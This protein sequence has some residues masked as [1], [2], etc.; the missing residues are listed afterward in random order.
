[1][2]LAAEPAPRPASGRDFALGLTFVLMAFAG[3]VR[4]FAPH[5]IDDAWVTLRYSRM[6]AE[7]QGLVFNPGEHVEGY[8]NFLL[9]ALLTPVIRNG[10]ADAALP[11]A[12]GVGL[13]ASLLAI[14]GAG[15]VAR[16]AAAGERWADVAG[17][18]AAALV[19]CSTGFAYYA[20]SGLETS[21][22]A[23]LL[24]W[25]ALGI[26]SA[27]DGGV[28]LG[29]LVLAAAALTRPEAPLVSAIACGLALG[30][31]AW[32]ARVAVAAPA[33][34]PRAPAPSWR[35]LGVAGLLVAAAVLGQLAFRRWYYDGEW[36][37]NTFYV[38]SGWL[39][40]FYVRDALQTEFLGVLGLLLASTGWVLGGRASRAS[41]VPALIG[42]AGAGLP[43]F[44]GGDGM[45][46]NRLIVPYLPLL[47]VGASLGWA[48]LLV[49]ARRG[50][51]GL[52]SLVMLV[53]APLGLALQWPERSRLVESA[54]VETRLAGVATARLADWIHAHATAGDAI[55]TLD[56]G[57][58]GYRCFEQRILDLGGRTDRHIG[59]S[60]GTGTDKRFDLSYVWAQRPRFVVLAL[61]G[62]E[63][64][65]A[66]LKPLGPIEERLALDPEFQRGYVQGVA[67]STADS[68][69][70]TSGD[71][72]DSLRTSL[73][74]D[75]VFAGTWLE[76]PFVFAV[77]SRKRE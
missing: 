18:T 32:E 53:S 2:R 52:M 59:Q 33:A 54:A 61:S 5:T 46:A 70:V 77:F 67:D 45:P 36:L 51:T 30:M 76:G 28:M 63:G 11:V 21:L 6:W 68:T 13:A 39:G 62:R 48:R 47:A 35:A 55:A 43:L 24:T 58:V 37:P 41:L 3:L 19:A 20:M 27:S 57:Q 40:I 4:P 23:C 73:G 7:G 12:K 74:A 38:R 71:R 65:A 9:A 22:C 8:S 34:V 17:I 64:F 72:L 60:P 25:G 69:R 31:R 56:I 66:P 15:L 14:V 1:M 29:G 49:R 44:A 16:R 75:A 10:G 26:A 42:V 50:G